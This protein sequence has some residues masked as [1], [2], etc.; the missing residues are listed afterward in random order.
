MNNETN[1]SHKRNRKFKLVGLSAATV[2]VVIFAAIFLMSG[3]QLSNS[4]LAAWDKAYPD[5]YAEDPRLQVSAAAL[6]AGSNHNTQPW[7]IALD[8]DDT[9]QFDLFANPERLTPVVD[10]YGRQTMISQGVF[11]EYL[12]TYAKSMGMEVDVELFPE[13]DFDEDNLTESLAQMPVARISLTPTNVREESRLSEAIYVS[14]TNRSPYKL[15]ALKS[16]MVQSIEGV[17]T[18]KVTVRVLQN[19]DDIDRLSQIAMEGAQVEAYDAGAEEE[20]ARIMRSN[21]YSKN[22]YKWGHVVDGQASNPLM[23]HFLQSALTVF[24]SLG[25][26]ESVAK[27]YVAATASQLEGTPAFV[28]VTTEE[29]DRQSQVEAGMA[30]AQVVLTAN[31]NYLATHPMSQSLQEFP[32]MKSLYDQV[33]SE[34]GKGGTIQMLARIGEPTQSAEPSMRMSVEDLKKV[35]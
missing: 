32:G 6:L 11:L 23:K 30:Y 17:S 13:G 22:K 4:Y 29:N 8:P 20:S 9:S 26:G 18:A 28:L 21:E 14:D 25:K 5:Q 15:Q 10:P 3:A 1:P 2:V 31:A 34:F 27:A 16:E 7:L 24:P 19:A 12:K 33:H 35:G